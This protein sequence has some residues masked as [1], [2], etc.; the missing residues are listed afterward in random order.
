MT[1]QEKIRK[2]ERSYN[3]HCGRG[4]WGYSKTKDCLIFTKEGIYLVGDYH[5]GEVTVHMSEEE[6]LCVESQIELN[7][8]LA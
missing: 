2:I 7:A 4:F 6:A 1:K 8:K 5:T 3:W